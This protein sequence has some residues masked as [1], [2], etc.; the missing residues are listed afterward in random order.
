MGAKSP[1]PQVWEVPQVFR[2]RLRESVGRQRAMFAEGHLLLVLHAPPKPDEPQRAARFFWRGPDGAWRSTFG[3]GIAAL[4]KHLGE[5]DEALAAL[6]EAE[7]RAD[8]AVDFFAILERIA[9]L[10]RAARNLHDTLQQA[11][12]LV[13]ED[14][15]LIV[16]RDRAYALQ[17]RAELVEGDTRSG[18]ECAI[19]RRAEEQAASSQRMAV[20]AHRLNM[21]AAV[22]FPIATISAIFQMN[23]RH[24]LEG[25]GSQPWFFWLIVLASLAIGFI[26]KS[27]VLDAPP[28]PDADRDER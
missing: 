13:S 17:R 24:G 16:C 6:D 21:L 11:R 15:D 18:L 10:R 22:F 20:S 1:L 26:L 27:A 28:K 8:R 25:F 2:Q 9:P 23:M 19:A 5:F 12:E 7:D 3:S 4:N 14:G